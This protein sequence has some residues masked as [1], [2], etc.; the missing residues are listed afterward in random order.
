[1]KQVKVNWTD[2]GGGDP[3]K[4]QFSGGILPCGGQRGE[5]TQRGYI[6]NSKIGEYIKTQIEIKEEDIYV[7]STNTTRTVESARAIIAGLFNKEMDI[8]IET[9]ADNNDGN[10]HSSDLA[11]LVK[12]RNSLFT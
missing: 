8:T 9:P 4:G 1:M 12:M 2:V 7:R 11:I 5:L 3:P 6:G 10:L